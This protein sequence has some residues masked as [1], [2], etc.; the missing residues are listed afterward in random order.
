MKVRRKY[1]LK[2][3]KSTKRQIILINIILLSLLFILLLFFLSDLS[4]AATYKSYVYNFKGEVIPSPQAYLPDN[5]IDNRGLKKINNLK[6]PQDFFV[7]N[8]KVYLLD[9]GN[10]RVIVLNPEQKWSTEKIIN[11]FKIKGK[12]QSF[13]QPTGIYV[14]ETEDIYIADKGNSRLI[15]LNRRGEFQR[16]IGSPHLD[17]EGIFPDNFNFQPVKVG[18]DESGRIYIIAANVNEG[19]LEYDSQGEFIGFIGAPRVT[20]SPMDYF[21]YKRIC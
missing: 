13:N 19:L 8:N 15:E 18:L 14:T 12:V 21:W 10:N 17:I 3:A 6:N 5:I 11:E 2:V 1:K 9:T 4:H 20:P 16:S 7:R